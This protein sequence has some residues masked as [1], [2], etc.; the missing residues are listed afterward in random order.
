MG[1]GPGPAP[2]YQALAQQQNQYDTLANQANTLNNRPNQYSQWGSST[3]AQ[4]PSTGQWSQNQV[5]NPLQQ[6]ALNSQFGTQAGLQGLAQDQ[7]GGIQQDMQ[8][9]P[10]QQGTLTQWGQAPDGSDAARAQQQEATYGQATSR[11][12]P[13]W[14]KAADEKRNQLYAM[15]LKEGN[16]TFDT[17]MQSFQRGQNDAYNQALYSSIGAGN[18]VFNQSFGQSLQGANYQNQLRGQQVGEAGQQANWNLGNLQRL[19]SGMGVGQQQFGSTPGSTASPQQTPDVLGAANQQYQAQAQAAASQNQMTGNIIGGALGAAGGLAKLSDERT[20]DVVGSGDSQL[21]D[22][23]H[24]AEGSAYEYK[25]DWKDHPLASEGEHVSP[26]AQRL[27]QSQLGRE[28]VSTGPS[29][30]KVVDYGRGLGTLTAALA[31]VNRKLEDVLA[32]RDE[33][34]NPTVVQHEVRHG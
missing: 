19:I 6:Q 18:D 22:F 24:S 25:D 33:D 4:D 15:G 7:L 12:D 21:E 17:E 8:V 5:L 28:M 1:K 14:Q 9:N 2:D 13:Q 31:L 30:E 34:V 23:L 29:G 3:W 10:W 16:P 26:M 11:L 20:K 27:E 32:E